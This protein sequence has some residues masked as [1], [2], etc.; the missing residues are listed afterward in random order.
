M[1]STLPRRYVGPERIYRGSTAD[2]YSALDRELGRKVA[3]KI[4]ADCCAGD[5]R[6]RA[7]LRREAMAVAR[8]SHVLDVIRIYDVGEW[9]GR[10]Y[11]TMEYLAGGSLASR[12]E[13][14]GVDRMLAL[15]WLRQAAGAIDAAHDLGLVHRDVTP[16]NLLLDVR[17]NLRLTDFGISTAMD[18][19]GGAVEAQEVIRGTDGF[20]APEHMAGEPAV[21]ASDV[22]ALGAVARLLL[23]EASDVDDRAPEIRTVLSHALATRPT[24]RNGTAL[25]FVAELEGALAPATATT[26]VAPAASTRVFQRPTRI[27]PAPPA[28]DPAPLLTTSPLLPLVACE[29]VV[30]GLVLAG[31]GGAAILL[32]Y[33]PDL[34][35]R[36]TTVRLDLSLNPA[37]HAYDRLATPVGHV[38]PRDLLVLGIV[39]LA[40]GGLYL[41][42]AI[43]LAARL[44]AAVYLTIVAT[45]ALIPFEVWE[46]MRSPARVKE[47]ALAVNVAVALSLL[48][49]IARARLVARRAPGQPVATRASV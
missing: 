15:R 7:W 31:I 36:D 39:A 13:T 21:P 29:R 8:L 27:F 18:G 37:Q 3:I 2:V 43:G 20:I 38:T 1:A 48:G 26:Q 32:R 40:L 9:R 4:L 14:G 11:M 35:I 10:P 23:A 49:T 46:I 30:R 28:R 17:D 12:L 24:D 19:Q 22:Y 33:R 25:D 34:A 45:V 5:D 16:H 44:R 41:V 6:L 47:I 42:E